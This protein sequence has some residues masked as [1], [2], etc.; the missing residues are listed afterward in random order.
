MIDL[1]DEVYATSF[2]K[3]FPKAGKIAYKDFTEA[4]VLY[5][6]LSEGLIRKNKSDTTGIIYHSMAEV[7][8]NLAISLGFGLGKSIEDIIEDSR[9]ESERISLI[10][11]SNFKNFDRVSKRGLPKYN[12][13]MMAGMSDEAKL[14]YSLGKSGELK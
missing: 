8:S 12:K 5:V 14:S 6:F 13:L 9:K 11:E 10:I 7:A 3:K 2:A 1:N 4:S